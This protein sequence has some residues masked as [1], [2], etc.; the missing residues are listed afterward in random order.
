MN[1]SAAKV[2]AHSELNND[3]VCTM[4][5]GHLNL[6][7]VVKVLLFIRQMFYFTAFYFIIYTL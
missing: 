5:D 7:Y 1:N 4:E 6:F 3:A 2:T